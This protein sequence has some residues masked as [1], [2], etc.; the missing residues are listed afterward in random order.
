MPAV[1]HPLPRLPPVPTVLPLLFVPAV[2]AVI[3]FPVAMIRMR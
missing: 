1:V 2:L 3:G